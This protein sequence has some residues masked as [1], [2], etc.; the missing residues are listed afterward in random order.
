MS[1]TP[2]GGHVHLHHHPR[3]SLQRAA[4]RFGL[5]AHQSRA[6]GMMPVPLEVQVNRGALL[7]HA[8]G[9]AGSA[10]CIDCGEPIPASRRRHVPN[11]KRCA[12]CQ[13]AEERRHAPVR[14]SAA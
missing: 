13:E 11:A 6:F 9:G 8:H 12:G 14:R 5:L 2:D 7:R 10:F 3:G 4:I 1:A